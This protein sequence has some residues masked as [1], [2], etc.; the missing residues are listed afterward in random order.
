MRLAYFQAMAAQ[1]IIG[2]IIAVF[3]PALAFEAI[4]VLSGFQPELAQL[5]CPLRQHTCSLARLQL[6]PLL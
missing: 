5:L 4:G 1:D 3:L 6:F 2:R